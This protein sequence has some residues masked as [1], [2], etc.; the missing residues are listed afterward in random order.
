MKEI[1]ENAGVGRPRTRLTQQG[2]MH[3]ARRKRDFSRHLLERQPAATAP[4]R[5]FHIDP[6]V[7]QQA[8]GNCRTVKP[9]VQVND[10][11]RKNRMKIAGNAPNRVIDNRHFTVFLREVRFAELR[12][13]G[14]GF[15]R[16]R[17]FLFRKK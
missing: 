11:R 6:E 13:G 7:G 1:F 9:E 17:R 15:G 12:Q 14:E 5:K 2:S 4:G 16:I 3:A 8:R 10:T